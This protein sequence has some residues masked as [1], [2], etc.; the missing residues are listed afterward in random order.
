LNALKRIISVSVPHAW[1]LIATVKV[2]IWKAG[3][4]AHQPIPKTDPRVEMKD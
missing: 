3:R 4:L 1:V 2:D